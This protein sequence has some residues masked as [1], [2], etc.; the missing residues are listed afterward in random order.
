M[1]QDCRVGGA[2]CSDNTAFL[3]PLFNKAS[4]LIKLLHPSEL[5]IAAIIVLE[6]HN[7]LFI[8]YVLL[9][10]SSHCFLVGG[11]IPFIA[12]FAFLI[13]RYFTSGV[14]CIKMHFVWM[15]SLQRV[16]HIVLYDCSVLTIICHSINFC[17]LQMLASQFFYMC[18][19]SIVENGD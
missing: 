1:H 2:I 7:E 12:R 10:L 17:H 15:G 19:P 4:N 11:Y 16:I 3:F 5:F 6:S 13:L 9:I 14:A 8:Y 18:F